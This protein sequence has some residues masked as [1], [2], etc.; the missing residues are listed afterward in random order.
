LRS[1]FTPIP[2]TIAEGT[3]KSLRNYLREHAL[4]PLAL[5]YLR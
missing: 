2:S 5:H 3:P 4:V 1:V